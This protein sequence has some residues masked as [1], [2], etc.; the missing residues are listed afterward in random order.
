MDEIQEEVEEW[1]MYPG[2]MA[3]REL[4]YEHLMMVYWFMKNLM[5]HVTMEGESKRQGDEESVQAWKEHHRECLPMHKKVDLIANNL[6]LKF[7]SPPPMNG[8][9]R[10]TNKVHRKRLVMDP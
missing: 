4:S 9:D 8:G 6:G 7:D 5:A 1:V 2:T 3:R 10:E